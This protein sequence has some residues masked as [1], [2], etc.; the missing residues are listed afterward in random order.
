[1]PKVTN[2]SHSEAILQAADKPRLYTDKHNSN[3]KICINLVKQ[4]DVQQILEIQYFN[5]CNQSEGKQ[6]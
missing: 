1:M 4:L 3:Y 2:I 5:D 6:R